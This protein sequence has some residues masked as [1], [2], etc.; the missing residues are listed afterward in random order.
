MSASPEKKKGKL[1]VV[2][3]D[4][5]VLRA[6]SESLNRDGFE[7]V[8]VSDPIEAL[9]VAK[10]T[11]FDVLVSD[12]KMPNLSGIDLLKAFKAAQP[13]LE[14]VMM[15]GHGTIETAV[16]CMK[17]GAYDYLSKP[18]ERLDDFC[19]RVTRAVERRALKKRTA[20]LEDALVAVKEYEGMI[21]QSSQMAAVFK[22]VDQVGPTTATV[23]IRGESGTGKELVAKAIHYRSP[24]KSKPFVA[25]NCS[26]LTETLLESELFGHVKGSFT[27]AVGNKRGLFEAA[28]EGTIFLDEIGDI[29]AATQVRLLRVLQEGEIKRVG[30]TDA[31]SVDTRVIAATNVDLEK[32]RAEGRFRED[33]YYRL[34][35]ITL[36][37]PPLRDRPGDVPLLAQ[38]FLKVFAEKM[39]KRVTS[40]NGDAM[41]LL[42]Q[43]KWV[44]NVRELENAIER[45]VVLTQGEIIT[46]DD[47]PPHF[48]EAPKGIS[49]SADAEVFSLTHL[50]FAQA[51]A[52][53]VGA[54]ERR[55][56]SA[57]LDKTAGN[58]T[59][60]ALAA[61]M[62]R[63]NF[64]RLL[65]DTGLRG[66][67]A[68]EP[69]P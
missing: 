47:L 23:L 62:D 11:S 45:A 39:G 49:P 4:R 21:G 67:G 66:S 25:V 54:F 52:L 14:V 32:A 20:V 68:E 29:S 8:S 9:T 65:K 58:I 6:V 2:D 44:G 27:G 56:L 28:D 19:L 12:I 31:I 3:D 7:V 43:N 36:S 69:A 37:L 40:I 18:F 1:L 42:V 57:L 26:A 53:A 33:L 59:A 10:D 41:Q 5:L 22:L 35:V 13:D 34:N 46:P 63:S 60:A 55:Y 61:G 50:P 24:R 17:L 51:K 15:S 16:E 48:K 30:S 64:R 38:H